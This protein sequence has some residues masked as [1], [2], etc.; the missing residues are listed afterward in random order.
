M[1]AQQAMRE[2][3]MRADATPVSAPVRVEPQTRAERAA[4]QK[5]EPRLAAALSGAEETELD[6]PAFLRNPLRSVE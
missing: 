1:N 4:A 6:I 5:V 2:P 3:P